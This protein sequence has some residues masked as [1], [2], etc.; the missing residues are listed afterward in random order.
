MAYQV[1][2]EVQLL[3]GIEGVGIVGLPDASVKESKDHVMAALYAND[4]E[5]SDK[6]IIISLS[7]AEQKKTARFLTCRWPPEIMKEV[8]EVK[9]PVQD[10]AAFLGVL[11]LDGS[12][13]PVDGM[14]PAIIAARKENVKILYLPRMDD[15]PLTHIDRLEFRFVDTL[16]EVI[17]SFS[18]QLTAFATASSTSIETKN[19]SPPTYDK[20]FQNV[21]GHTQNEH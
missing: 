10:D 21:L 5:V 18:G 16:H 9:E 1:H 11:S 8:G 7:L 12:I 3:P 19:I 2:V 6:K 4:C 17:E 14:L 15:I 13:K 20:D